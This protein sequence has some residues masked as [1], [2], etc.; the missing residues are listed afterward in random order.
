[1]VLKISPVNISKTLEKIRSIWKEI[2]PDK[3]FTYS[4]LDENIHR[5]FLEEK[6]WNNIVSYSSGLAILIACLGVFGLTSI[7]VSRR[8]REIGIRKVHGASVRNIVVLLSGE[9]L[10]WVLIAAVI[11]FPVGYYVIS[12]WL[13]NFAY[14]ISI[15]AEIYIAASLIMMALVLS[16]TCIQIFRAA[17]AK[18]VDSLRYE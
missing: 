15:S 17:A 12:K 18:P 4:F 9:L 13:Q 11:S 14:K 6:R 16:T 5:L 8:T 10:R 3:P 7:S 1:M 2:Q